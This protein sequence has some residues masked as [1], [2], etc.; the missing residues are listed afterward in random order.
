[1]GGGLATLVTERVSFIKVLP[2]EDRK[3][4]VLAGIA[5]ALGGLFVSPML[6][7]LMVLELGKFTK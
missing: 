6:S 1:M 5:G 3:L 4:L 2:E 7:V